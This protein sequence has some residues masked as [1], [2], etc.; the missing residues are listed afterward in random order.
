MAD[1]NLPNDHLPAAS[2]AAGESPA[3]ER[4]AFLRRAALV[5]IPVLI[6]TVPGRTVWARQ[7]D[8]AQ[9]LNA[10]CGGSLVASCSS[11]TQ[12]LI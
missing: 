2:L 7:G 4:R 3:A 5:G 9:A 12:S 8:A 11:T 1:N 6:A 10:T